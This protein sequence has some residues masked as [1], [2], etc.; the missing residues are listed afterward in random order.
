MSK[1]PE[2]FLS[3]WKVSCALV[4]QLVEAIYSHRIPE[5]TIGRVVVPIDMPYDILSELNSIHGVGRYYWASRDEPFEMAGWGEADIVVAG[6]EVYDFSY[7]AVL[8]NILKKLSSNYPTVRY[9]GGFKFLPSDNRGM[10]WKSFHAYRFVLPRLELVRNDGSLQLIANIIGGKYEDEL[11]QLLSVLHCLNLWVMSENRGEVENEPIT[12]HHRIDCPSKTEWTDL[13]QRTLTA[14]NAGS[15]EKVVLA[16]ETTF[17]SNRDID[18]ISLLRRIAEQSSHCYRFCFNPSSERGFIGLSPER[19]YRRLSTYIETEA[20]AGTTSRGRDHVEDERLKTMLFK[21]KKERVEHEIVVN[22]L[23]ADMERLCSTYENDEQPRVLTLPTVHHLYTHFKGI[24]RPD[25]D[26]DVILEHLHPTPAVGGYPRGSA[27]EWI[28]REESLDRGIYSA[29]VGWI[30][31]SS[32]EFCAGIRSALVEKNHIS[33]YSG[34]GI[35]QGSQPESEWDELECKIKNYINML[36][37]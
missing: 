26:D 5:G 23:K 4:E 14:I 9:Y 29:P 13:I 36:M 7:T 17:E 34:A 16:R 37:S 3:K 21:N 33:L 28:K 22:M 1:N 31:Y 11:K 35:V 15:F 6:E 12:F 20:L 27:L 8:Q 32:A 25:V 19:L 2:I 10:R 30:S 24:L 18:P